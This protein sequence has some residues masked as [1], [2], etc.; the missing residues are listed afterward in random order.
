MSF[1]DE[2][3]KFASQAADQTRKTVLAFLASTGSARVVAETTANTAATVVLVAVVVITVV[4]AVVFRLGSKVAALVLTTLEE[5]RHDNQE[6]MN[7]VIAAAMSDLLS[8]EIT[9]E[10][11]PKGGNPAQ[12]LERA[13]V[14]GGKLHDLLIAEFGGG[15]GPEGVDGQKAARAFSG[16]NINF[17]TSAALLS[18]L[19]EISSIGFIK[20]FRE[21]GEMMAQGLSLGRLHR[22]ALKPLIDNLIVHPYTR[23][24]GAQYRQVRLSDQQYVDALQRGDTS[25]VNVTGSVY[26]IPFNADPSTVIDRTTFLKHMAEKGYTDADIDLLLDGSRA[27]PGASELEQAVRHGVIGPRLA[28]ELLCSNGLSPAF[29]KMKL[30]SI[31]LGR[32][33]AVQQHLVTDAYTLARDRHMDELSF[34]QI[35]D[36]TNLTEGEKQ[37]WTQR[38]TLTLQHPRKRATLQELIYLGER[39]QIN[40]ADI[41]Q[42]LEDSGYDPKSQG[43]IS[44]YVLGKELDFDA[45]QK[46]KKAK[47]DSASETLKQKIAKAVAEAE[48]KEDEGTS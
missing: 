44:L 25:D 6:A 21:V 17:N 12:Q 38:L 40:D 26:D 37:A 28:L 42:W 3:I 2:Q 16:F 33:D 5:T 27:V 11:I 34:N 8:V 32:V 36:S 39:A 41:D 15:G 7:S 48:A 24:L 46:K 13:R 1:P 4:F 9:G 14:I 20:E 19:T 10:D 35:L 22:Q 43:I 45:A 23:Q 29:A 31:E 30:R 18:I 47:E